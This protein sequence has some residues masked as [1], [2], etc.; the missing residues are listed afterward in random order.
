MPANGLLVHQMG[1]QFLAGLVIRKRNFFYNH[2]VYHNYSTLLE[3]LHPASLLFCLRSI[4]KF[5][6]HTVADARLTT[7]P[8]TVAYS[9]TIS[10]TYGA[11][12]RLRPRLPEYRDTNEQAEVD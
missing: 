9:V 10:H 5:I 8:T 2:L 11:M 7:S 1:E 4:A 3:F 6:T 12:G